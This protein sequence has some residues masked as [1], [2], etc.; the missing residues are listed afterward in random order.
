MSDETVL[1]AH[2]DEW[3]LGRDGSPTIRLTVE[4]ARGN[5]TVVAEAEAAVGDYELVRCAEDAE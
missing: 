4:S 1:Q 5:R 3:L 2:V